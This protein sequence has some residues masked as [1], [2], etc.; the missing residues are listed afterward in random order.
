[1]CHLLK[2]L[3]FEDFPDGFYA[4][5][6]NAPTTIVRVTEKGRTK[7]VSDYSNI[8]TIEL[9]AIQK[10]IDSIAQDIQWTAK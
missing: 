2:Q 8:G 1:M 9:W 4:N 6:T 7:S 5:W 10:S 3:R